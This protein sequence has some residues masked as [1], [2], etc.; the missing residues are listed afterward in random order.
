[1]AKCWRFSLMARHGPVPHWR[2]RSASARAQRALDNLAENG[3]AEWFGQGRARRWIATNVPGF[4]TSL[5]LP[6]IGVVG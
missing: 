4:P 1:M 6:A 3:K 2:W 5:L